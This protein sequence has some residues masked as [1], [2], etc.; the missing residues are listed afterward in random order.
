[1]SDDVHWLDEAE[2]ETWTALIGLAMRLPSALDEQLRREAGLSHFEY[3][4]LA[5]L[6]RTE[7][8]TRRMSE[9][10]YLCNGSLS[11]LSHVARRLEDAG[12][13]ER[14]ACP[15]DGRATLARLT[16]HGMHVLDKAAPGH[17]ALV[18]ELVFDVL[19]EQ[20]AAQFGAFARRILTGLEEP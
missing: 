12:L 4:T 15:A 17:V 6:E 14:F 7:G 11:R 3:G 13:I 9:L 16:D 1:M 2:M 19:D 10:A 5:V 8:R 18:R 20:E